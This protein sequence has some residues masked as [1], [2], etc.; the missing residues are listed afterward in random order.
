MRLC[1]PR[2]GCGEDLREPIL[3]RGE[4][5]LNAL[6][7]WPATLGGPARRGGLILAEYAQEDGGDA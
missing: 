5:V 7:G 6:S 4:A 1:S 2:A 3:Q